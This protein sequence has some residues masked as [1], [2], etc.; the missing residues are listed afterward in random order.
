MKTVRCDEC[1]LDWPATQQDSLPDYG[2]EMTPRA[3]GYYSG[4]SDNFPWGEIKREEN[5]VLCH[6][7]C[8][9]LL[10]EFPAIAKALGKGGHHPCSNDIP[11]CKYSWRGTE[12]F[13]KRHN[14]KLVRTQHPVLDEDTGGLKWQDDEPEGGYT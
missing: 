7:C 9:R 10:D 12:N 5:V 11:C 14:E 3:W 8:V 13:G 4:F 1:N 2:F 6:D